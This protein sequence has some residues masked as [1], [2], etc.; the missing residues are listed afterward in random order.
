[1]EGEAPSSAFHYPYEHQNTIME[2]KK[3]LFTLEAKCANIKKS[4]ALRGGE[5]RESEALIRNMKEQ[6]GNTDKIK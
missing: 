1:M 2:A 6:Y 3:C 5:G 4:G